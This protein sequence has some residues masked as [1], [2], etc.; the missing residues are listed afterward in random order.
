MRKPFRT[1]LL[2]SAVVAAI[3]SASSGR[4][5]DVL[6]DIHADGYRG[7]IVPAERLPR[8]LGTRNSGTWTLTRDEA[9]RADAALR[10]YLSW[11]VEKLERFEPSEDEY[12]R[13]QL[14]YV[15]KDLSRFTR[16]YL[17]M[18]EHMTVKQ[19]AYATGRHIQ[20]IGAHESYTRVGNRD[21]WLVA[22]PH[23]F[24]G[25]CS[26]WRF[27]WDPATNRPIKFECG[28]NP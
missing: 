5:L 12:V 2:V 16:Y 9:L 25:A 8:F 27:Y 21:L 23:V 13:Q 4:S 22:V 7:A 18:F 20:I 3:Q 1:L 14:R 26:V 6:L 17:G 24:D 19:G 15:L 10:T 11:G 28:G